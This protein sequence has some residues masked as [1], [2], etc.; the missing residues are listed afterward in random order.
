MVRPVMD[1]VAAL[2]KAPQVVPS[3][4]GRIVIEVRRGK[5]DTRVPDTAYLHKILASGRAYRGRCARSLGGVVPATVGQATNSFAMRATA[6]LAAAAGALE[7]LLPAD[8]RPVN[9][10]EFG[11]AQA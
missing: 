5:N 1:Q 8:L 9:R 3:I 11:A 10:V 4:V 7:P 6:S 2:A